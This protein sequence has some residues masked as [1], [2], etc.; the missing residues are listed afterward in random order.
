MARQFYASFVAALFVCSLSALQADDSA[1]SKKEAKGEV[2]LFNGK[3]FEGWTHVL[4]DAKAKAE[5]VWS[6]EEGI[7]I[8]KGKPAG[9]LRTEKDFENYVLTLEWR[10]APGSKGGNS[11]VLVHTSTPGEIGVWPKSLEVQ[12]AAENAG[13]FWVIGETIKIDNPE[14]RIKG[15]RHFN[16]TDGSENPP[17]EWNR[18]EITCKADTIEVKVNGELV[19]KAT[20]LSATQGAICLQSEGAE[21][22]FRNIVLHPIKE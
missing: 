20:D 14:G 5:D 13:D 21:V 1:S 12:L 2:R 16:L 4:Q 8:C 10:W 6:V 9:Y 17:G 19:N 15:R 22:H 3:N 11:G 7:L 18:L